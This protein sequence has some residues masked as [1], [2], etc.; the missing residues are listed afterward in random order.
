MSNSSVHW[1]AD[2]RLAKSYKYP[3][4]CC[5]MDCVYRTVAWQRVDQIRYNVYKQDTVN[6]P[7]ISQLTL[8]S[9]FIR[10]PSF[11]RSALPHV[12][13]SASP[14]HELVYSP[15][16]C[17]TYTHHGMSGVVVDTSLYSRDHRIGHSMEDRIIWLVYVVLQLD[18]SK[19]RPAKDAVH[20]RRLFSY[21]TVRSINSK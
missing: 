7:Q 19:R 17:Y 11:R 20:N 16:L 8:G 12:S 13:D 3:S 2:C 5:V 1:H 9:Q 15:V 6:S 18:S 4:Y 14:R 10:S 21:P